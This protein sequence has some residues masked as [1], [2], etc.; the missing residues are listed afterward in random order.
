[1]SSF[2]LNCPQLEN[3]R[4]LI[5][6]NIFKFYKHICSQLPP[7]ENNAPNQKNISTN[8]FALPQLENKMPPF[9]KNIFKLY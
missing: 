6:K 9:K 2:A 5:K 1:M 3:K 4:P 8:T 7:L